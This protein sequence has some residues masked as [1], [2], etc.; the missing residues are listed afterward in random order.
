MTPHSSQDDDTYRADDVRQTAL[1]ADP[2]PR[3][4]RELVARKVL[5]EAG[6]E[7]EAQRI[8]AEVLDDE[9]RALAEPEPDPE[10]ARRWLF[11]GDPPHPGIC[12]G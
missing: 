3:L 7:A 6:A 9:Q 11:A 2:L 5:D 1:A 4:C 8:R 12:H 10:R